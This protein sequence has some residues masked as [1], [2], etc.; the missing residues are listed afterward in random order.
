MKI[1][2]QYKGHFTLS[3]KSLYRLKEM[4]ACSDNGRPSN[5]ELASTPL[6]LNQRYS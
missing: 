4:S 3:I 6:F 2:Q 1:I 5:S